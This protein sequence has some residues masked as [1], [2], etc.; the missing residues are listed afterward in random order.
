MLK[1]KYIPMTVT[2][3]AIITEIVTDTAKKT[4]KRGVALNKSKFIPTALEAAT[5]VISPIASLI[6]FF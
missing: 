4:C 2:L 5:C 1:K 6:F 3:V